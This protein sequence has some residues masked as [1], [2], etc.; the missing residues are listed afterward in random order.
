[1]GR[2]RVR[3][4]PPAGWEVLEHDRQH[5]FRSG[6]MAIALTDLGPADTRGLVRDI[7]VART[8]WLSGRRKDAFARVRELHGPPLRFASDQERTD[9]WRDWYDTVYDVGRVDSA[10]IG[11]AFDGLVERTQQLPRVSRAST[12][13]YVLESW[14]QSERNEI[15][16]MDRPLHS[17]GQWYQ[18]RIWNRV[19]HMDEKRVAFL[20][21][22]GYFLVLAIE[23]GPIEVTG[24]VFEGLLSSIEVA[25]DSGATP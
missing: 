10:Q 12:V 25:S 23:R 18:L 1:M 5:L 16:Q 14:P 8:V 21:D 13:E 9:Y 2:H 3:V 4:V 24:P 17:G 15:A 19:S 22:R 7:Q 20:D 6:E 11:I